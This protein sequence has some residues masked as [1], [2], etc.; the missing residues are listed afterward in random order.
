VHQFEE[1]VNQNGN[2]AKDEIN[3]I[4][5]AHVVTIDYDDTNTVSYCGVKVSAD[6]KL[7]ILFSENSLGTNEHDA[8]NNTNLTK[9]LNDAPSPRSM[10]FVART[11]IRNS[12]NTHIE[13]I[14]QKLKGMLKQEISLVPNFE[15]NFEKLNGSADADKG[16]ER[17]FGSTHLAYFEGLATQ[18]EYGK[19]GEDD[20]LQE[21]LLEAVDKH[22]VH[23]RVVDQTKRSYNEAVIEGGI[24]YLQVLKFQS[25]GK[26]TRFELTHM[27]DYSHGFWHQHF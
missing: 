8:A 12:Y 3:E 20:M 23:I 22:A 18:L 21:A 26:E 13:Q 4:C 10:N 15:A 5:S 11:S 1:F 9:A 25:F 19:F 6:G 24:L 16:W 14:Q 2:E 27:T 17:G 7:V